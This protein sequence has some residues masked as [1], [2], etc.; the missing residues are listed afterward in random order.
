MGLLQSKLK[1]LLQ[2][3]SVEQAS[4]EAI[5][6]AVQEAELELARAELGLARVREEG[7]PLGLEKGRSLLSRTKRDQAMARLSTRNK[8]A[9]NVRKLKVMK[10]R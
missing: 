2:E 4:E 5:A 3:L 6:T 10:E 9:A 1:H 7:D 8:M